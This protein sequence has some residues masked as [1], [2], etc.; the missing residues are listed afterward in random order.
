MK[1][2]PR[3]IYIFSKTVLLNGDQNPW[4][5]MLKKMCDLTMEKGTT[6][7]LKNNV[8]TSLDEISPVIK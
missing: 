3:N 8:F 7:I 6:D 1:Y 5:P 4:H 2:E